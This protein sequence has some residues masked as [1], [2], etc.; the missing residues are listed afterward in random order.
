MNIIYWEINPELKKEVEENYR[1][2]YALS[3]SN[4]SATDIIKK[5]TFDNSAPD[6]EVAD[7]ENLFSYID[8]HFL[9]KPIAGTGL[10]LGAGPAVFSSILVKRPAI[11]KMYAVEICQSIVE[12]L[13]HKVV[14]ELAPG[15]QH[16][17]TGCIGDFDHLELPDNSVDFLLDFYSLHHSH[18]PFTT[19]SEC[20]RVLKPGG[21]LLALD[22]ARPDSCTDEEIR[23]MLELE[24]DANYKNMFGIDTNIKLTRAMNGEH[25]YRLKEWHNFFSKAGFSSFSHFRLDQCRGKNISKLLKKTLAILPPRLQIHLTKFLPRQHSLFELAWD[26]RVFVPALKNFRKEISLMIAYK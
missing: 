25:E 12:P 16:K 24:Y 13:A 1:T 4:D 15:N 23:Q 14:Q 9:K 21:F 7:I 11:E 3:L 18:E 6:I 19:A 17:M 22:K 10:E 5:L 26:N 2:D 8:K 20:F